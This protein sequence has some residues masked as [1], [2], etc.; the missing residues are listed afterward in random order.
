MEHDHSSG[1]SMVALAIV[2]IIAIAVVVFVAINVMNLSD[3]DDGG[4][5]PIPL[6]TL[7]PGPESTEPAGSYGQD[8]S[9]GWDSAPTSL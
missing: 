7:V 1:P 6:Q 8:W 4:G 9:L 2:A 3:G 5:N